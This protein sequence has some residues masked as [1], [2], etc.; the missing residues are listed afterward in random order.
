MS[1]NIISMVVDKLL[2]ELIQNYIPCQS[3]T[4]PKTKPPLQSQSLHK[5][6][7]QKVQ[8]D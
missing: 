6:V 7:W 8:I 4:K 5:N 1:Q 2:E 3:V